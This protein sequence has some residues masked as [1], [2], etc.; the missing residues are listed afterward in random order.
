MVDGRGGGLRKLTAAGDGGEEKEEEGEGQERWSGHGYR[1]GS[2]ALLESSW[3]FSDLGV[4]VLAFLGWEA[5]SSSCRRA[6]CVKLGAPFL[7]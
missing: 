3:A 1:H 2:S 7:N 4:A 6:D 5:A